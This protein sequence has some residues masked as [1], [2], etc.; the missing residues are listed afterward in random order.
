M[1]SAGKNLSSYRP[2]DVPDAS[3]LKFGIVVSDFNHFITNA[4]LKACLETLM[5]HGAREDQIEIIRVPGAFELPFGAKK[6]IDGKLPD[7]VIC[8]GCIIKGETRHDEYISQAVA[9]GIVNL[10]LHEK[11]PVILGVL[12]TEN[13]EQA[14]DRSGGKRG[15]KGVEAA[16]AA[17]R[18]ASLRNK[19]G[20]VGF[21]K[22]K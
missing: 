2:A 7:A 6:L 20:Q 9:N 12:T 15:N 14:M 16:V 13:S 22:E 11:R 8:L 4:L 3:G 21:R 17:I 1:S 19:P 5:H 18:M 10:S